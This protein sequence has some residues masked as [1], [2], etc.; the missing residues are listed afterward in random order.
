MF[1]SPAHASIQDLLLSRDP[2]VICPFLGV[3]VGTL[4][5][6][7]SYTVE[8]LFEIIVRSNFYFHRCAKLL[9]VQ[10]AR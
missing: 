6:R 2:E 1:G 8:H 3:P 10:G 7:T 4:D 5:G 9:V